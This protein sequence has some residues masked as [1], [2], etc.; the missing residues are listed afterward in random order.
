MLYR[1]YLLESGHVSTAIDL[2][3]A[4]DED[5]KRQTAFLSNGRDTELWQGDRRVAHFR[6]R[7]RVLPDGDLVSRSRSRS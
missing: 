3:C 6:T 2:T 7:K 5:A 4:D 1:A